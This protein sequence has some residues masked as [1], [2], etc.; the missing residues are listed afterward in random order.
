MAG[1]LGLDILEHPPILKRINHQHKKQL[2]YYGYEDLDDSCE[3]FRS[4]YRFRENT[5][6]WLT[7]KLD[8]YLGPI[9]M[10]NDALKADQRICC[11]LRFY[12]TGGFQM[13]MVKVLARLPCRDAFMN[14]QMSCALWQTKT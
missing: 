1:M 8:S 7:E 5:V 3:Q 2:S 12:A 4:W 10:C 11:A 13:L 14:A 9:S 6:R